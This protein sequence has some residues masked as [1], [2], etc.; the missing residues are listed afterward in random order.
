[1]GYRLSE[2]GVFDKASDSDSCVEAAK[3]IRT[4]ADL[5]KFFGL[6]M[7]EPELREGLGEI[8]AAELGT[9]PQL[10]EASD[11]CGAFHNHTHFLMGGIAWRQWWLVQRLWDGLTRFGRSF[12]SQ[13]SGKWTE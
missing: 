6:A 7:I 10:V 1:M 5:F 11:I 12:K 4:E 13:F 8:E 9:M 2:W 3:G